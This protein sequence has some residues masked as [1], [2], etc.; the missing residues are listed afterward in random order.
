MPTGSVN[1]GNCFLWDVAVMLATDEIA[2]M[3]MFLFSQAATWITGQIFVSSKCLL[4]VVLSWFRSGIT[5]RL[6]CGHGT[7]YTVLA[8][9]ERWDWRFNN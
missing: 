6:D 9:Y 4:L 2:T 1:L 5:G 8:P 7:R 3:G